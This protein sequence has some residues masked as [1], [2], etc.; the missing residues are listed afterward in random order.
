MMLSFGKEKKIVVPLLGPMY[1]WAWYQNLTLAGCHSPEIKAQTSSYL[2]FGSRFLQKNSVWLTNLLLG[3]SRSNF[4]DVWLELKYNGAIS[5][6][7][8]IFCSDL[9]PA[10]TGKMN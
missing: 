4:K 9:T 10:L 6:R 1:Y 5:A 3:W 2:V 7:N 8:R